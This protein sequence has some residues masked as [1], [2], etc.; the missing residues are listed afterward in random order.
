M[1]GRRAHTAPARA[2][3]GLVG[4]ANNRVD[5][6][7][8]QDAAGEVYVMTKQEGVVYKLRAA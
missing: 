8:G 7:F 1:A 3:L 2:S 4:A 5:L 6:R